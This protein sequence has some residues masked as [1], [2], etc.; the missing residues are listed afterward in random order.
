MDPKQRDRVGFEGKRDTGR[1]RPA[2]AANGVTHLARDEKKRVILLRHI[3]IFSKLGPESLQ[4]LA[5]IMVEAEFP[6]GKLLF[7]EGEPADKVY[8]ILQGRVKLFKSSTDG[9]EQILHILGPGD[10]VN[11]VPFLDRGPHPASAEVVEAARVALLQAADFDPLVYQNA[12]IL[13]ELVRILGERL[14]LATAQ[15]ASLGTQDALGRL[16]SLLLNLATE[17][18]EPAPGREASVLIDLDLTRQELANFIG[19]SRETTA[20]LLSRLKREG[21][22]ALDRSKIHVLDPARLRHYAGGW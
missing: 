2:P 19:L 14:R 17:Y 16:S 11:L 5:E 1:R 7:V 10:V 21:I 20:R 4:K 18:G 15:I 3:P 6:R 13:V 8:F 9:R 12:E 22:I